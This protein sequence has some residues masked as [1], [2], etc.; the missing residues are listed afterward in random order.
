[1]HTVIKKWCPPPLP[2]IIEG[3]SRVM[4]TRTQ[5]TK[6]THSYYYS[7]HNPRTERI[8]HVDCYVIIERFVD[9]HGNYYKR[10]FNNGLTSDVFL[11]SWQNTVGVYVLYKNEI[12]LMRN[13]NIKMA[14]KNYKLPGGLEPVIIQ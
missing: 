8:H 7:Y 12:S 10:W 4:G 14:I 3:I 11:E 5:N 1:M 2:L 6:L 13:S 9:R